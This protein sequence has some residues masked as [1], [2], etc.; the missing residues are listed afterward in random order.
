MT[1]KI[2][3]C[4]MCHYLILRWLPFDTLRLLRLLLPLLLLLLLPSHKVTK[5]YEDMC[6]SCS[7]TLFTSPPP[8]SPCVYIY[9]ERHV[10]GRAIE[11][12]DDSH[13]IYTWKLSREN[14]KNRAVDFSTFTLNAFVV[15]AYFDRVPVRVHVCV[16]LYHIIENNNKINQFNI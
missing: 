13:S 9:M 4:I 15:F 5:S 16:H 7:F 2:K 6:S 8:P 14:G 3:I 11:S 12:D 10:K 1:R